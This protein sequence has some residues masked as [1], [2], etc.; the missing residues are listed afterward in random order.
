MKNDAMRSA[1]HSILETLMDQLPEDCDLCNLLVTTHE[2]V[3][4]VDLGVAVP[5]SAA[6]DRINEW[7]AEII[8]M[9]D[10]T[11]VMIEETWHKLTTYQVERGE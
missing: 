4:E 1:A 6:V 10:P 2:V 8:G 3:E 5:H 9:E 11:S 7:G